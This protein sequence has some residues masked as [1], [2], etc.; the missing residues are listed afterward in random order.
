M[1]DMAMKIVPTI[2]VPEGVSFKAESLAIDKM[3]WPEVKHLNT[4]LLSVKPITPDMLPTALSGWLVDIV[5][6]MD[7]APLEYAAVSAIVAA[8]SLIGRKLSIQPKKYDDWAIVPNLWGCCIGRP[9]AKKSP[10]M[11]AAT[12]PLSQLETEAKEQYREDVKAHSAKEKIIQMAVKEAEKKAAVLVKKGDMQG[13]EALLMDD[14]GD[15]EKPVCI[16][17]IINDATIEKL[18]VLL[19]DNKKGLVLF[20]DELTGWIAGLERDDRQQD[21]AFWLEAFNGDGTFSYDRISR[22]DVYI[23]SNTVSLLGGIQPAKL[24]PLLMG[25]RNGKGDDGLVERLQLMVYPDN[26]GFKYSDRKPNS[27]LKS[28]AYKVFSNLDAIEYAES[29][30]DRPILK[31]DDTA[32]ALFNDW[33]CGLMVRIRGES[34]SPQMESHLGK[35]PSLMPSLAGVFHVID[36]GIVGRIKTDS[37]RMAIKWCEVLE[38]HAN[39][40]YALANDP[41]A[42]ARVLAERLD[43]LPAEFKMDN[44]RDKGWTGLTEL[45]DRERALTILE[46][47]GYIVRIETRKSN[48]G[49]AAISF[50]IN[51]EALPE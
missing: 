38:T 31:F 7:N 35:Y 5:E 43:K 27:E 2:H 40:I 21:R 36:N 17:H 16:R 51:P 46:A 4:D 50:R 28:N 14:S 34:I 24:L 42:G 30:D 39:R 15:S 3:E 47:H 6:R 19:A 11:K 48:R 23:P 20:R 18:G 33:Y 32:Q 44:L 26:K 8:S 10:V 1:N 45:P 25:Q 29:D 9:S 12:K 13:A 49:R 37:V 41:L 22:S